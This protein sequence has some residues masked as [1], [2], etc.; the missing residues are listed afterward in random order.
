MTQEISQE[1]SYAINK[2][3]ERTFPG[4]PQFE[5]RGGIEALRRV[6]LA[7]SVHNPEVGYC[8]SINFLAGFLLLLFFLLRL[9]WKGLRAMLLSRV[10][11]KARGGQS[12]TPT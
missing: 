3:V 10:P 1:A 11:R 7:F 2:D 9:C 4:H 12:K 8:Q 5:S 6:L